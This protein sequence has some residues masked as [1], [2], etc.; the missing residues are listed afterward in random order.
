MFSSRCVPYRATNHIS[1]FPDV[2][3]AAAHRHLL[4]PLPLRPLPSPHQHAQVHVRQNV[5]QH[6]LKPA[7]FL[8]LP[9]LLRQ[10]ITQCLPQP[11]PSPQ[12][13]LDPAQLS[14]HQRVPSDVVSPEVLRSRILSDHWLIRRLVFHH[15][16]TDTAIIT[17]LPSQIITK[18]ITTSTVNT[19]KQEH[20]IKIHTQEIR[21]T[22]NS[23]ETG[24]IIRMC[25]AI[26]DSRKEKTLPVFA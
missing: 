5:S 21:F 16:H 7:A 23:M 13:A 17:Q 3:S 4:L 26:R 22:G 24:R 20:S 25:T 14:A 15:R 19:D 11:Y 2:T 1:V 10:S 9:L 12:R 8:P 18:N 6:V